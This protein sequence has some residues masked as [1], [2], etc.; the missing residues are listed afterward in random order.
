RF[1]AVLT[2]LRGMYDVI[3]V[4]SPPMLA[5]TDPSTIAPRVDAVLLVVRVRKNVKPLAARAA[6]MLETLEANVIGVVVNGVGSRAARGYGK[7]ADADGYYNR[8]EAY[9]YGYGYSYGS[10]TEGRYNEYY[11]DDDGG[12]PLPKK[13]RVEP[14]RLEVAPKPDRAARSEM[15]G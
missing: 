5:V 6:R 3:I 4:D 10:N 2:A 13:K 7:T 14:A 8:G 15:V 9:Q 11:S 1:D 12:L